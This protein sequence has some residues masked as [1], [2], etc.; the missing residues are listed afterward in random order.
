LRRYNKDN[1]KK[2]IERVNVFTGV[3]Y[4]EDPTI[5]AWELINEPRCRNCAAK[6]QGW[7][8]VGRCRLTPGRPRLDTALEAGMR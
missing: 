7:I 2:L 5:M 8:V 3:A 6:L 1:I 4:R